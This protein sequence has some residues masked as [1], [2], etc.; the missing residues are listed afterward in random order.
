MASAALA[1]AASSAVAGQDAV[2]R[3][4]ARPGPA[5]STSASEAVATFRGDFDRLLDHYEAVFAKLG[6]ARGLKLTADARQS[7]RAV[8]DE[9][10]GRV[11][12]R[13]RAP[14]LALALQAAER[15][16]SATPERGA[17]AS[18]GPRTPG[19]PQ[20]PEVIAACDDIVHDSQFTFGALVAFQVV[21]TILAAAEFVCLETV[22]ILGE[23][24]NT[25]LVCVPFAVGQ[26]V[27]A[28]PYELADFC[29]G[30]EDSALAQGS[31]D[32]LDHIHTD[33]EGARADIIANDNTNR[34]LI[35]ANDNAN[36]DILIGELR[37]LSCDLMRLSATPLGQRASD[38]PSCA[39]QPQFPYNFPEHP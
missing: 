20:A 36:R 27:A 31:Y 37:N 15:L 34:D 30:E 18:Q 23:G 4:G 14:D 39:G 22:V 38:N 13:M 32:R 26:D 16:E 8:S 1:L 12:G 19:F 28:I 33:L 9:Q 24:G 35:I 29:G 11:F 10:L 17:A 25:S 21:R 5:A 3:I 7:L 6:D 2:A